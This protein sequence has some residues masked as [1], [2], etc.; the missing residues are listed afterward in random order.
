LPEVHDWYNV[1]ITWQK[2]AMIQPSMKE[3]T[4]NT[5]NLDLLSSSL[6]KTDKIKLITSPQDNSE[7]EEDE[8]PVDN[9]QD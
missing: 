5:G 2:Q 4:E 1:C 8:E 7:D 6:E 3:Q 9:T